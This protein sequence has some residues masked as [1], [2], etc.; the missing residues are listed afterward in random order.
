[1]FKIRNLRDYHVFY[2]QSDALLIADVFENYRNMCLEIYEFDP[3]H[4][5]SVPGLAW[6]VALKNTKV[7]LDLLIDFD[8]LLLVEK[9]KKGIKDGICHAIYRYMKA[10]SKYTKKLW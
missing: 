10:N 8:M 5:L 3:F 4:F 6:Q 1:M 9:G 2:I 7:K